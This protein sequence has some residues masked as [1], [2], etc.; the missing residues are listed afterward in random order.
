VAEYLAPYFDGTSVSSLATS[1]SNYKAIDAWVSD[2]AM[3]ESAY[4]NLLTVMDEAGELTGEVPF[5]EL[6]LTE[7]AHRIYTEVYA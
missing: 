4:L 6:V 3:Q 2:M 1:I 5:D 7:T